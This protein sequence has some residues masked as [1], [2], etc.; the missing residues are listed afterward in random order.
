VYSIVK[1][2][3][4]HMKQGH[5][6]EKEFQF[7]KSEFENPCKAQDVGLET[8]VECLEEHPYDC[9]FSIPLDG[10]YYCKCPLCVYIAKDLN[11]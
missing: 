9:P 6:K 8:F 5:E 1:E 2:Q 3:E 11:K 7:H 4:N 10:L